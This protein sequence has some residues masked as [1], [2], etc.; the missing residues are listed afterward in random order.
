MVVNTGAS[1][2]SLYVSGLDTFFES[3][4]NVSPPTNDRILSL[5]MEV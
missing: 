4:L 1:R 2:H 5:E 3:N